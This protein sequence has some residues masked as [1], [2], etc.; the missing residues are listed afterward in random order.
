MPI[1]DLLDAEQKLM[2]TGLSA[3][4]S[5]LETLEKI[6]SGEGSVKNMNGE[7]RGPWT[8]HFRIIQPNIFGRVP[9]VDIVTRPDGSYGLQVGFEARPGSSVLPVDDEMNAH[10]ART[11]GYHGNFEGLYAPGGGIRPG[12]PNL[13]TAIREMQEEIGIKAREMSYLGTFVPIPG[14][15]DC[16]Q[17]MYLAKGLEFGANKLGKTEVITLES[18]PLNEAFKIAM[19]CNQKIFDG[20]TSWAVLKSYLLLNNGA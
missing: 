3:P 15:I 8:T 5:A 13:D 14:V 20:Q 18:M 10:F 9:Y 7:K 19:D 16:P 4:R 12:E 1:R 11:I 2:I 17:Y 6:L